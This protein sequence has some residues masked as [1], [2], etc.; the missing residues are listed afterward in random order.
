MYLYISRV[1]TIL[2]TKAVAQKARAAAYTL[3]V[4]MADT[5][6]RLS[7]EPRK[8]TYINCR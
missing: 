1:Q 3:L 7:E 4:E 2:C 6:I 5:M 8:R